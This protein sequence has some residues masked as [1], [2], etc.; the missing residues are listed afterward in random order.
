MAHFVL[1]AGRVNIYYKDDIVH[2]PIKKNLLVSPLQQL[3]LAPEVEK[4]ITFTTCVQCIYT[5]L[6]ITRKYIELIEESSPLDLVNCT[7]NTVYLM[8]SREYQDTD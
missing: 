7:V 4:D 8:G 5:Y 6:I 2:S 1:H 3:L